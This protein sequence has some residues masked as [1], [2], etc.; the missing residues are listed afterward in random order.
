MAELFRASDVAVTA[1]NDGGTSAALILALSLGV[2]VVAAARPA[3]EELTGGGR[4]GWHFEPGDVESLADALR[5]AAAD[6]K[7][8]VGRA[9]AG[10][11]QARALKWP[12]IAARTAAVFRGAA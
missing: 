9:R 11:A 7:E 1:R 3:Y 2:S 5:S 4:A 8:R 10:L 12:A 6:P